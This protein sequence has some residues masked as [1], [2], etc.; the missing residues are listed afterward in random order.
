MRA[1]FVA[2]YARFVDVIF[3]AASETV[4]KIVCV[5]EPDLPFVARRTV[6]RMR[7]HHPR[8]WNLPMPI[9]PAAAGSI[10]Y[11]FVCGVGGCFCDFHHS[12]HFK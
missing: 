6:C 11:A 12:T 9:D 8:I 10:F 5:E 1:D 4:K 2:P 3:P 7:P